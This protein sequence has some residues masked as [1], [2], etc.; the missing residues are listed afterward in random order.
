MPEAEPL[1]AAP[2]SRGIGATTQAPGVGALTREHERQTFVWIE[3]HASATDGLG[4]SPDD[5]AEASWL[6]QVR[7]GL[8]EPGQSTP[9]NL[10]V[11][12]SQVPATPRRLPEVLI[13]AVKQRPHRQFIVLD[14]DGQGALSPQDVNRINLTLEQFRTGRSPLTVIV[15][16]SL[17]ADIKRVLRTYGSGTVLEVASGLDTGFVAVSAA[18]DFSF[19]PGEVSPQLDVALLDAAA[20]LDTPT[21]ETAPVDETL[22][23]WLFTMQNIQDQHAALQDQWQKLGQDGIAKRVDAMIARVPDE[24]A[25]AVLKPLLAFGPDHDIVPRFWTAPEMDR[26]TTI[27]REFATA[28]KTGTPDTVSFTALADAVT[29]GT[30]PETRHGY[31]PH[32]TTTM[33]ESVAR[34]ATGQ[35]EDAKYFIDVMKQQGN[36]TPDQKVAWSQAIDS[37]RASMPQA[38]T[39]LTTL[40]AAILEC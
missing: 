15:R 16:G 1:F 25:V 39:Q 37:L 33:L 32:V 38:V 21:V 30:D 6:A 10:S 18:G 26:P 7:V 11:F 40:Q 4:I 9:A 23:G 35:F 31:G 24:P 3:E 19:Q 5:F 36:L 17:D 8:S 20:R 28:L 34:A 22:G 13:E 2:E 29:R 14:R 27:V 12:A